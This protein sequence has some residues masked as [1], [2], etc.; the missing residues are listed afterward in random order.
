MSSALLFVSKADFSAKGRH[1]TVNSSILNYCKVQ[2]CCRSFLLSQLTLTIN[3]AV[4][5]VMLW[6]LCNWVCINC[7]C[8]SF[9]INLSDVIPFKL[10]KKVATEHIITLSVERWITYKCWKLLMHPFIQPWLVDR[11]HNIA[12]KWEMSNVF[13]LVC[14]QTLDLR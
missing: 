2:K 9:V 5:V 7:R 10:S 8:C 1:H 12:F 6:Y 3:Q 4:L 13:Y 11:A 14:V